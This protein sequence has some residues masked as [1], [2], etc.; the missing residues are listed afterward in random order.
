[1][2][3]EPMVRIGIIAGGP[4]ALIAMFVVVLT[5]ANRRQRGVR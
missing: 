1:M 5:W 2:M 4:V 3:L